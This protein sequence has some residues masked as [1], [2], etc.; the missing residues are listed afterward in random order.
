MICPFPIRGQ[1]GRECGKYQSLFSPSPRCYSFGIGPNV[2]HRLVKGLATVSKGSAEF[3]EEGERL[4]PK[5]GRRTSVFSGAGNSEAQTGHTATQW[6]NWDFTPN[7]SSP[8]GHI[9]PQGES[10]VEAQSGQFLELVQDTGCPC[11]HPLGHM[12]H[13]S[14]V[15]RIGA[16][17]GITASWI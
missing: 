2:C 10:Q 3:L 17:K 9:A 16:A 1:N 15:G 7:L 8:L 4:Q 6:W 14:W 11:L 5:V 13:S 12:F